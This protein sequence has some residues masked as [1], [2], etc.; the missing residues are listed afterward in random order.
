MLAAELK[1]ENIAEPTVAMGAPPPAKFNDAW[2]PKFQF[3]ASPWL[4]N[5]DDITIKN[6][7]VIR[8]ACFFILQVCFS[9]LVV[10]FIFMCDK[11]QKLCQYLTIKFNWI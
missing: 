5:V 2:L 8:Q 7:L 10:F 1:L 11:N 6:R 3:H 9:I 4:C